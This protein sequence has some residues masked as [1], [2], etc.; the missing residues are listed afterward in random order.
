MGNSKSINIEEKSNG[1]FKINVIKYPEYPIAYIRLCWDKKTS[2]Y[3]MAQ[4][5]DILKKCVEHRKFIIVGMRIPELSK[6][7]IFEQ[8][9]YLS[10]GLNSINSLNNNFK[11]KFIVKNETGNIWL[12]FSG[13][14][15]DYN[16][17]TYR[18]NLNTN[19]KL[20]KNN[21]GHGCS[22]IS[23]NCLYGRF[24]QYNPNLMQISY[25]LGGN[26]W[27]NN[28]DNIVFNKYKIIKYPTLENMIEKISSVCF[29]DDYI[30]NIECSIYLNN[31]IGSALSLNYSPE[32]LKSKLESSK[33]YSKFSPISGL[34]Y[35]DD[36]KLDYR[37]INILYDNK[38]YLFEKKGIQSPLPFENT[39]GG[40]ILWNNYFKGINTIFKENNKIFETMILPIINE[41]NKTHLI[42]TFENPYESRKYCEHIGD[43]YYIGKKIVQKKK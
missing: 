17:L 34:S 2:K 40:N 29:E 19:I 16:D 18:D 1:I 25:C 22:S 42:G 43:Y 32:L 8:A 21:F 31:Y 9:F 39:F 12:P 5:C 27:E 26:F 28:I 37:I 24:G 7:N 38:I 4:E 35:Y 11:T 10:S 20:L 33:K 13:F 3:C 6:E 36:I 23:N 41:E 15:Y 30:S 14:G